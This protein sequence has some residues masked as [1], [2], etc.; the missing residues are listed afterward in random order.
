M[1]ENFQF[2]EE[3]QQLI[4]KADQQQF[5]A[6]ATIYVMSCRCS[7]LVQIL[8]QE[9]GRCSF[10]VQILLQ[11][12]G[13]KCVYRSDDITTIFKRISKFKYFILNGSREYGT[14]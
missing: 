10:L 9:Q 7:F 1:Q 2:Y 11:E 5:Q 13:N 14:E 4:S 3:W 6:N 8:L 12:Q